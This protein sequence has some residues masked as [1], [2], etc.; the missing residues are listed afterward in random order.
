MSSTLHGA[1]AWA[2]QTK[3]STSKNYFE[4][5]LQLRSSKQQGASAKIL[6]RERRERRKRWEV[7]DARDARDVRDASSKI[8]IKT[9]PNPSQNPPQTPQNRSKIQPWPLQERFWSPSQ[10][11]ARKNDAKNRPARPPKPPNLSQNPPQTPPKKSSRPFQVP[12]LSDFRTFIFL[13][14]ICNVF[15]SIFNRLLKTRNLKNR[16]PVEVGAQ[17]LQNRDFRKDHEK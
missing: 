3:T 11:Q 8:A 13:L 9:W 10:V 17:F 6:R 16:A 5:N 14:Q 4:L 1:N 2:K 7:R 12:V 15:W